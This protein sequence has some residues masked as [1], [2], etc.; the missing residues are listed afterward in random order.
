[1]TAVAPAGP[2]PAWR[3]AVAVVAGRPALFGAAALGLVVAVLL[4]VLAP[5]LPAPTR[6]LVAWDLG[7]IA[8]VAGV[9]R[10]MGPLAPPDLARR[11][12]E[13][14]EG[15]HAILALC[16]V[17]AVVS[18][19]AIAFELR[20]AKLLH[21]APKGEHVLF[22]FVTVGLSW[23]FVHVIFAVHYAH[24]YYAPDD[25]DAGA[26]REGLHFPGDEP[27]DFWDFVHFALV[28]GV[29]SQTADVAIT[30]K[31]LRRLVTVHGVVAFAFNTTVLALSINLAAALFS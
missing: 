30:T 8:F 27:P 6:T 12:R 17:A 1:M 18:V 20:T 28:I 11:A 16:V 26:T 2:R 5:A 19:A 21:G 31:P 15:R 23:L 14:D 3:L 22:A 13:Q 7:V 4:R 24:E 9:S 10:R 25:V 29:A